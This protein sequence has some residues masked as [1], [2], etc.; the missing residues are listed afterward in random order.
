MK[1]IILS[2][3]LFFTVNAQNIWYVDRDATGS[4]TGRS[5]ANAWK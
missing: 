2:L 1:T 3:L 5:W 4:N